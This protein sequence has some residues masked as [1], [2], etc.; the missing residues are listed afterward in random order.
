MWSC[1]LLAVD[2]L[3]LERLAAGLGLGVG[4]AGL[5]ADAAGVD[6]A[7]EPGGA[8]TGAAL[9]PVADDVQH[10]A[11]LR[12]D[13]LGGVGADELLAGALG[14]GDVAGEDQR[15]LGTAVLAQLGVLLGQRLVALLGLGEGC[16][17]LCFGHGLRLRH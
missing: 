8:V 5:E 15:P 12:L 9:L 17:E 10:E 4:G 2:H 13:G 6:P 1:G 16:F 11:A 7:G 14:E 3:L